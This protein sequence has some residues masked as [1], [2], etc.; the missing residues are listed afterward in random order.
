MAFFFVHR[1]LG[2]HHD[3]ETRPLHVPVEH[4]VSHLP[5]ERR[6]DCQELQRHLGES[7]AQD[8]DQSQRSQHRRFAQRQVGD[9]S[10]SNPGAGRGDPDC[11]STN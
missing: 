4:L 2:P 7:G 10:E 5:R 6:E 11:K 8:G 1:R 9:V 3:I